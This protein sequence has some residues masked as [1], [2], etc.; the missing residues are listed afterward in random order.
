MMNE[1]ERLVWL[2]RITEDYGTCARGGGHAQPPRWR[3][4]SDTAGASVLC[5]G[6]AHLWATLAGYPARLSRACQD[7]TLI[8]RHA[9]LL[10]RLLRRPPAKRRMPLV[11]QVSRWLAMRR[12]P[13]HSCSAVTAQPCVAACTGRARLAGA[14]LRPPIHCVGACSIG[15]RLP[16]RGE[17]QGSRCALRPHSRLP[18]ACLF[19][20]YAAPTARTL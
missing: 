12:C 19:D 18:M 16:Q 13:W 15:G 4:P 1:A 8:R 14:V 5:G 2:S 11:R 9:K 17:G 3:L 6:C 10:R 20:V 7:L